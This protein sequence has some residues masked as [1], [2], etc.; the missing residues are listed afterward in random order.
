MKEKKSV[1]EKAIRLVEGGAVE[2]DCNW[3]RLIRFPEEYD[4]NPCMD[5]ELDSICRMEHTDICEECEAITYRKCCL[6]L[7]S[8]K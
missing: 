2:I 5:C 4:G 1:H 6:Q 8:N 3:F 7:A